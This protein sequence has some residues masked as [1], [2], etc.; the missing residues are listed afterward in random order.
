[1]LSFNEAKDF[2]DPTICRDYAGRGPLLTQAIRAYFDAT[3]Q[4][5]YVFPWG[6]ALYSSVPSFDSCWVYN[7]NNIPIRDGIRNASLQVE[8]VKSPPP[9]LSYIRVGGGK[10][11]IAQ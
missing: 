2:H 1:M 9:P 8:N 10:L 5:V 6:T 7:S 3:A 4:G 11:L